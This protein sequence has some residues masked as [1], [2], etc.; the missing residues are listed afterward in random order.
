MT[1]ARYEIRLGNWEALGDVASAIRIEVFVDEQKVPA[2]TEMDEMD[3]LSLHVVAYDAAGV[4]IGTGRLLPDG[5][6][7]RIAVRKPGRGSGV[8]SA[9]FEALM[10]QA[11]VRGDKLL[12]LNAVPSALSFYARYGFAQQGAE[13]RIFG[14][15][16][17]EMS[18]ALS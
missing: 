8:G 13:F 17:I 4:A 6:I 14:V 9:M 5:H 18:L 15:P 1:T 16:L 2:A 11:K 7:G 3:P 12:V 10:E